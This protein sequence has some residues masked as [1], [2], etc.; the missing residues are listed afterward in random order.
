MDTVSL[1][2]A[3]AIYACGSLIDPNWALDTGNLTWPDEKASLADQ[4]W[5]NIS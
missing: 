3:E 2:I 4:D 1:L 5:V